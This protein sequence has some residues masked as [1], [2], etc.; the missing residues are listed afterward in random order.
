MSI[1]KVQVFQFWRQNLANFVPK[2][3]KLYNKKKIK[4][5]LTISKSNVQKHASYKLHNPPDN[6]PK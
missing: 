6:M 5:H 3:K 4:T 2:S 1:D